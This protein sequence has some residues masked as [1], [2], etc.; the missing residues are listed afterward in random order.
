M[1]KLSLSYLCCPDMCMTTHQV[2]LASFGILNLQLKVK[3]GTLDDL[4]GYRAESKYCV[5]CKPTLSAFSLSFLPTVACYTIYSP[6]IVI[7][8]VQKLP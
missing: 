3:Y 8:A 2:S 4:I 7:P 5:N 6:I 1:D